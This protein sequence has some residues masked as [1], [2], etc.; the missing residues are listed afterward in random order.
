MLAALLVV[1]CRRAEPIAVAAAGDVQ[2]GATLAASPFAGALVDGDVRFVNLEGPLT[3]RGAATN[4]HFAFDPA[5]AAWLRGRVD[6]VSLANNH[7][8]DQGAAARDDTVRALAGVDVAAAY[9]GHDAIVAR[10]GRRVTVIARALAPDAELDGDEA[11]ALVAAVARA[12]RPTIVSL[13]WGHT[14][15]LLPTEEQKRFAHRLVDA[16]AVAVLG[17]GPHTMQGVERYGRGVIAY[18]LG[19]FAFG[20]DCTDVSDAYVLRFT[21]DAD[22]SA[23]HVVVTPIV[24]GLSRTPT[25]ARD[26]GLHAQL[27]D[28]C[29]DLS[30]LSAGVT[31]E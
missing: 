8:L 1:G 31:V 10:R 29:R 17:H 9:E 24:A 6:V 7:A 3:A 30:P 15:S 20:C 5:R 27:V 4:E 13:H 26:R 11:A 16:G 25:R 14:G 22:G 19:N 28:L 2:L 21:I 12:A 18:S 23:R